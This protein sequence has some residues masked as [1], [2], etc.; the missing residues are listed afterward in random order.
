[1]KPRGE[2]KGEERKRG[3]GERARAGVTGSFVGPARGSRISAASDVSYNKLQCQAGD[4]FLLH[5]F[6]GSCGRVQSVI[7]RCERYI[8]CA[9]DGKV[10]VLLPLPLFVLPLSSPL[11]QK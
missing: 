3:S 5:S 11:L 7:E 4:Y 10:V 2:K 1:M 8:S 6:N 9:N